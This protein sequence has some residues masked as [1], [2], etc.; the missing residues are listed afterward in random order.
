MEGNSISLTD[1]PVLVV[2]DLSSARMVLSDMLKDI[3]FRTCLEAKNGH[4][5]LK[6]LT[7]HQVQLV[8][9]DFLMSGMNGMDFLRELKSH[10]PDNIPP[11]IFVSSIGDVESVEQAL[12]LG[13]RDYLVKPLSFGKLRRKVAGILGGA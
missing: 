13:A 11:I 7:D 3:G 6:I 10:A 8:F 12:K 2:D 4:E 1:K 9:C 5:A